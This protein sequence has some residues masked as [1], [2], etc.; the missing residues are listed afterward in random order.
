M[1]LI[2][3]LHFK[4]K[5]KC[6]LGLYWIL[7]PFPR[8]VDLPKFYLPDM[9]LHVVERKSWDAPHLNQY[10]TIYLKLC[11]KTEVVKELACVK[12][13]KN[14]SVSRKCNYYKRCILWSAHLVIL[15]HSIQSKSPLFYI[16][17]CMCACVP[18]DI[19]TKLPTQ[20]LREN[21][22]GGFNGNAVS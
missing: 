21:L 12:S 18:T 2:N 9:L 6:K 10:L 13:Q 22:L 11:G 19:P 4:G 8:A 15:K 20:N 5:K 7:H 3:S 1:V 16:G 17:T 14:G